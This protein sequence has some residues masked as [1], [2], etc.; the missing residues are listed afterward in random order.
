MVKSDGEIE[1]NTTEREGSKAARASSLTAM[2]LLGTLTSLLIQSPAHRYE[3]LSDIE[4]RFLPALKHGQLRLFHDGKRAVGFAVWAAVSEE[5]EAKIVKGIR[6]LRP[7]DWKS[8]DRLWLM[9]IVVPAGTPKLVPGLLA[10]LIKGP[11]SGRKIKVLT[12]DPKTGKAKV[13]EL[14]P[15]VTPTELKAAVAEK[16]DA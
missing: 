3:Y 16:L 13:L 14:G 7:E 2:E 15:K 12:T 9:D 1:K 4:W 11:L 10:E 6:K 5:V 8:G